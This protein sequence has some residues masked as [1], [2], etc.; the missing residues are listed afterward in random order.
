MR[1]Q[2]ALSA[3][4]LIATVAVTVAQT[5]PETKSDPIA[6]IGHGAI[7]G[8][9]GKEIN[10]TPQ[11]IREAQKYYIDTL[12]TQSPADKRAEFDRKRLSVS[13]QLQGQDELVAN[14]YLID[15]LIKAADPQDGG[16]LASKNSLLKVFLLSKLPSINQPLKLK[17][18]EGYRPPDALLALLQR[19]RLVNDRKS[20]STV[21]EER[22]AYIKAC[23]DA[24]V[25]IPPDWDFGISGKWQSKQKLDRDKLFIGRDKPDV[26]VFAY[27]STSPEGL[28]L[29]LPRAKTETSDIELLGIIC[30]GKVSSKACFWDN[31]KEDL[32]F[33][34][35][36]GTVVKLTDFAGGPELYGG[37]GD[38]CTACHA[39]EN[40]YIL[41]PKTNLGEPKL[42]GLKLRSDAWYQPLVSP[43]WPQNPG[44]TDI[45]DT[46]ASPGSCLE[47]HTKGG[48]GGRLPKISVD[49]RVYCYNVLKNAIDNTMPPHRPKDP[50]YAAHAN[51]LLAACGI[52]N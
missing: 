40:P 52:K 9:D 2:Y 21:A 47:C 17:G 7:F 41:H 33:L 34:I 51:A 38:V 5:R 19:E 13:I 46:I 15:F 45:L 4:V 22:L 35:P 26:E 32:G 14:S 29:A 31:Q 8:H 36:R 3:F 49:T 43:R 42:R 16:R 25:P 12:Y 30:L 20:S 27:D 10:V 44:A 24:S 50:D 1:T 18:E 48:S 28:C 11:F 39:G 23:T 6:F 37:S